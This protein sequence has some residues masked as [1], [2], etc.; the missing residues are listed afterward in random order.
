MGKPNR[1]ALSWGPVREDL[2][3]LAGAQP[4]QRTTLNCAELS[5]FQHCLHNLTCGSIT[6]TQLE[7][8]VAVTVRGCAENKT[9]LPCA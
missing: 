6:S 8:L 1:G 2:Q 3:A 5:V 4:P 9:G 7:M